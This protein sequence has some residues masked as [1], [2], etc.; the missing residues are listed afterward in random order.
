MQEKNLNLRS[1]RI[2][3]NPIIDVFVRKI[4]LT[5][6]LSKVLGNS[7]Y[8]EAIIIL[9]KNILIDRNALYAIK[10]WARQYHLTLSDGSEI[11]DDRLGRALERLYDADRATLQTQISLE[12]VKIFKLNTDQIHSDT[13]SVSVTGNYNSQD[14]KAL[15][16]K[17]GHSKDHRPD[18]KQLIYSLCVT[19]DGAVPIHFKTYDGNRTDDTIQWETWNSIRSLFQTPSFVFVGDS[20]LCV[21]KTLRKIDKEHG[22]FVTVVPRTRSEVSDFSKALNQG[23]VRWECILRRKSARNS[24]EFES[25]ECAKG[26]YQLREGFRLYW[27]RSSQKRKRDFEERKERINRA[28]NRLES[29]D[30]SR[31]RGPKT[32]KSLRSRIDLI[33]RRFRVEDW[34]QVDIKMDSDEKFKAMTRGKP[35]AETSYRRIVKKTPRL[36]IKKKVENISK[37]ELMDGIFPLATNTKES[38]LETLKIYK[39]QPKIE[40]R[41]ATLKNTLDVAPIWLKK[42]TRIEALMFVEYL[43]QMIAALIERE[44]REQ[45]KKKKIKL[46]ASLPEGRPSQTPTFEQLLRLFEQSQKHELLQNKKI[47]KTFQENLLPVQAQILELLEVSNSHYC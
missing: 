2:G 18:L 23:D 33:L 20:K 4:G 46:L 7:D 40:K 1:F 17:R 10:E 21:E 19:R 47:I 22:S 11:G 8:A 37:S 16:L 3:C 34:L 28:W 5:H 6:I 32:E 26:I 36:N 27:F 41:H 30:L 43:A 12:V 38:A 15:Q 35:T 14:T 25:F 39:Y 44:M 31:L 42:N 24:A 29:L 13:T 45:M 9:M